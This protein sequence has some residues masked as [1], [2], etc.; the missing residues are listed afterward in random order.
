MGPPVVQGTPAVSK[1]EIRAQVSDWPQR[2][3]ASQR[4]DSLVQSFLNGPPHSDSALKRSLDLQIKSETRYPLYDLLSHSPSRSL[5]RMKRSN[6]EVMISDVGAED[7]NSGAINQNSGATLRREY[8]S[9]STLDRHSSSDK[10]LIS[11][12]RMEQQP[13]APPPLPEPLRLNALL[14]PS[15][16]TAIQIAHGD[17]YVTGYDYLDA[18]VFYSRDRERLHVQKKKPER[19]ETS[20]FSR[21]RSQR[22][23]RDHVQQ[24]DVRVTLTSQ[25][26]FSHYDVQ[27]VLFNISGS[28]THRPDLGH[29]K[30][31]S[32]RAPAASQWQEVADPMADVDVLPVSCDEL[33]ATANTL[34]VDRDGKKSRLVLSCP[35][36]LNEIGGETERMLGLT[37]ANST[38]YCATAD[39]P[40]RESALSSRCTNAGVSVLEVCRESQVF[41]QHLMKNYDIEHID[42]GAK[43]Y[44]KYFYSR[45]KT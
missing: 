24:Q 28:S 45:G 4:H 30:N 8:G 9:T 6:S 31:T 3:E 21:L 7:L 19:T 15:L 5:M 23:D 44:L 22:S 18:S 33:D 1:M 40:C 16:Q 39:G 25:K 12:Q 34:S 36:F 14:S 27:S 38:T 41:P 35:F 11:T 26:C 20:I 17:V 43:Y 13:S 2:R 32:T 29:R 37:R 10:G 42:L